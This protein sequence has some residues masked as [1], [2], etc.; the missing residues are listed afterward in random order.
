M[1]TSNAYIFDHWQPNEMPHPF[2]F[3]EGGG[4][5]PCAART[6][7]E[8]SEFS[9][10]LSTPRSVQ[11]RFIY[12]SGKDLLKEAVQE[13]G[14]KMAAGVSRTVAFYSLAF[15]IEPYKKR[16]QLQQLLFFPIGPLDDIFKHADVCE[17][18]KHIYSFKYIQLVQ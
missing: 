16:N 11:L 18:H 2:F 6:Y 13:M 15:K 5:S 9:A 10:C 17:V 12:E 3:E 7:L 1:S 8:I 4:W 14:L